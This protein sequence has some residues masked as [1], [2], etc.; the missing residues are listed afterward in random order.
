[1]KD[2]RAKPFARREISR[3]RDWKAEADSLFAV[4]AGGG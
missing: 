1:L 2:G 4:L 3:E